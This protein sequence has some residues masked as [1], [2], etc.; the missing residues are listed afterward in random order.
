MSAAEL[1]LIDD[2][3]ETQLWISKDYIEKYHQLPFLDI[4]QNSEKYEDE[5][6]Y[7]DMPSSP[8]KKLIPFLMEETMDISSLYLKDNFDMYNI[9]NEYSVKMN[10]EKKNNLLVHV[11]ELFYDYLKLND[12][13]IYG[14]YDGRN[15]PSTPFE[16]FSSDTTKL[17]IHGNSIRLLTPQWKEKLLY[18]SLLFKMMNITV[19]NVEYDYASTIPLEYIYFSNIKDIFPLLKEL[20]I[21]VT[22]YYKKTNQ[23]INP[24]SDEY[25]MEY[26]RLFCNDDIEKNNPQS[27]DYYT[28]SEMEE[29]PKVSFFTLNHL[30]FS[31]DMIQS[32]HKRRRNNQLPKLYK[33]I[34]NE[35][36]YKSNYSQLEIKVKK[37]DTLFEDKVSIKYDDEPNYSTKEFHRYCDNK[38]ETVTII[39]HIGH[40]NYVNIYGGYID[41]NRLP[42]SK[43]FLFILSNKY[44]I[45]PTQY[46]HNGTSRYISRYSS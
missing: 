12:F 3:Y 23:L 37:D 39:K 42:S 20:K 2:K 6:Y 9:I 35:A 40:N 38:G 29:Y 31:F 43:E 18:Y 41:Q 28:E 15:Q 1:L 8:M 32:I 45:P 16:L 13:I 11:K 44:N 33:Y 36:I 46:L 34:A 10:D 30:Y 17:T 19:V 5:S 25:I 4:I 26:I 22:T 21:T 24:N 14:D 7:I 27:Y